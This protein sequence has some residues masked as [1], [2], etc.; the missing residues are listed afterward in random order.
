MGSIQ[1]A[2]H[3]L[4]NRFIGFYTTRRSQEAKESKTK[5][6]MNPV[7][8]QLSAVGCE[9]SRHIGFMTAMSCLVGQSESG[10]SFNT[11]ISTYIPICSPKIL[12]TYN[13]N[14]GHRKRIWC[15]LIIP[16]NRLCIRLCW[17]E[18]VQK[19]RADFKS[20]SRAGRGILTSLILKLVLRVVFRTTSPS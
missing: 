12:D 7:T 2:S 3:R 16:V 19:Y 8:S 11:K 15:P 13:G 17:E 9:S 14:N 5:S 18:V 20:I 6:R 4:I 10:V 1:I